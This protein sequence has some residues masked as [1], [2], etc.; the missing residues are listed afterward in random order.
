[1]RKIIFALFTL[2]VLAGCVNEEESVEP[3]INRYEIFVKTGETGYIGELVYLNGRD[4]VRI[5]NY[6]ANHNDFHQ[7]IDTI[8]SP[9]FLGVMVKDGGE[10][11]EDRVRIEIWKNGVLKADTVFR[12]GYMKERINFFKEL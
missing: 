5:Y 8:A 10:Y 3:V 9:I 12:E 4:Q 2:L 11:N 1:M 6:S 7:I